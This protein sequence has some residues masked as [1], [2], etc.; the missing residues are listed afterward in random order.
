MVNNECKRIGFFQSHNIT[1][2]LY[3]PQLLTTTADVLL[4]YIDS[5][6]GGSY[7]SKPGK[8]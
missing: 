8:R 4:Y 2:F 7:F 3:G 6:F 5:R 1:L